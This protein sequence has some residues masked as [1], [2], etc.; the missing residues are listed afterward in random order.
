MPHNSAALFHDWS[1][2]SSYLSAAA[3]YEQADFN[4][5]NGE[6]VVRAHIAQTSWNF[7]SLLGTRPVLGRAFRPGDD[8]KGRNANAVIGYGLWQQLYAGDPRVLGSTIRVNGMPLTIVGV[9]PPGFEYPARTVL[10]KAAD[11]SP[12]NNGWETVARLKPGLSWPQARAAFDAEMEDLST[13]GRTAPETKVIPRLAS[14]QDS[15]AGPARNASL[16][17]LAAVALIFCSP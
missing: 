1:R 10:W 16:L 8:T 17:L 11:F 12:G 14:L 4:L 3:L 7:F 15:L 6:N 5:G 13:A 2:Q 9:A